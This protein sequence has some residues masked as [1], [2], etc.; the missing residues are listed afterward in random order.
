MEPRH[1]SHDRCC[2][3]GWCIGV[4]LA[5]DQPRAAVRHRARGAHRRGWRRAQPARP[6]PF[7]TRVRSM[8]ARR[9]ECIARHPGALAPHQLCS[10]V[11]C[12]RHRAPPATVTP[13]SCGPR[14]PRHPPHRVEG[15]PRRRPRLRVRCARRLDSLHPGGRRHSGH[16]PDQGFTAPRGPRH[17]CRIPSPPRRRGC[18]GNGAGE[19]SCPTTHRNRHPRITVEHHSLSSRGK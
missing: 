18:L 16:G 15:A 12:V 13:H 2:H 6:S 3:P 9:G 8:D 17:G 4:G 7:V 14:I 11:R 1:S 10:P 5:T 19:K